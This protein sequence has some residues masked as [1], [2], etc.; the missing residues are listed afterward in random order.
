MESCHMCKDVIGKLNEEFNN[1]QDEKIKLEEELEETKPPKLYF[2]TDKEYY[3]TWEKVRYNLDDQFKK[4]DL[5][6]WYD[7]HDDQVWKDIY[8]ILCEVLFKLFMDKQNWC[9]KL[10][11]TMCLTMNSIFNC[12]IVDVE[13]HDDIN[14]V[15]GIMFD[16]IDNIWRHEVEKKSDIIIIK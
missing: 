15:I 12:M 10:A 16:S 7:E 14:N 2:D 1:L 4:V 6:T 11:Y 13:T 8:P 9:D 5:S 3:S